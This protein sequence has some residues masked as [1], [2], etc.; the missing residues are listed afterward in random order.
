MYT[1]QDAAKQIK[2]SITPVQAIEF[3]T[4]QQARHGKYIC[5]FHNDRHPSL[6]VKE[7][8]W[9]CWSCNEAGDVIDLVQ[10]LYGIGFPEAM[11]KLN[12]DFN[13][14]I[15][16]KNEP[17][18][19]PLEKLWNAIAAEVREKNRKE[20]AAYRAEIVE[21][22]N[23]ITT[24]HR[25]LFQAGA[26]ESL[27]R[28]YANEIDDLIDYER[29]IKGKREPYRIRMTHDEIYALAEEEERIRNEYRNKRERR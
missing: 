10:K 6:S 13:L 21:E 27:L 24:I 1:F 7:S 26:D 23:R 5:P 17:V 9:R 12:D 14:G 28:I 8:Y 20:F 4:G 2:R 18:T 19:D 15:Q 3:Y 29:K 11:C 25:T 22:I 16:F